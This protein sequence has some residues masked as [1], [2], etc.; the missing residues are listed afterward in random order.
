VVDAPSDPSAPAQVVAREHPA[1]K[2]VRFLIKTIV[3]K[4]YPSLERQLHIPSWYQLENPSDQRIFNLL[5]NDEIR[6][7]KETF[8]F[9]FAANP[10]MQE[11]AGGD[12]DDVFYLEPELT[13][14]RIEI[15]LQENP[16]TRWI[17]NFVQ[18]N[19]DWRISNIETILPPVAPKP[20]PIII[21]KEEKKEDKVYVQ[22]ELGGRIFRGKIEKV[23]LVKGTTPSELAELSPL[24]EAA[25]QDGGLESRIAKK[26]L[27][28]WEN[29]PIPILLN[30]LVETPL[31]GSESRLM[32]VA[33]IDGLLQALTHRI[34]TLPMRALGTGGKLGLQDRQNEVLG[35]WF[36]WWKVWGKKWDL[37]K[38]EANFPPPPRRRG[39]KRSNNR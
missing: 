19:D 8:L 33:A 31:D 29:K 17:F 25:L 10:L 37:W 9:N 26:D 23:E 32:E 14:L 11:F 38:K 4:N 12:F 28:F 39:G 30:R 15:R 2:R 6:L 27:I 21:E 13:P 36:T 1:M 22:D 3:A 16:D 5:P 20:D 24:I 34:S 7:W 35:S 18:E